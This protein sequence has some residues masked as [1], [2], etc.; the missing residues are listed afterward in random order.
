MTQTHET[1]EEHSDIVGGSTAGRRLNCPRSYALEQKVPKDPGSS[2]AREGTALHEMI[3]LILDKDKLP[4]ELLPFTFKRE[5]HD[6]EG[7]WEFTVDADLWADVGQPALDAFDQFV[8]EIEADQGAS[9]EY[10]IEKRCA[11]PGIPGAFGTSDV[12]WK[13]GK[14]SGVWDWKFGRNKVEAD[15]N[16]QL[17]FYGRAAAADHPEMF[18]AASWGEIDP[19]R[20]VI[21]S[22]MQPKC[23]DEPSEYIVTVEELEAFRVELMKAVEVAKSAGETA[24][25]AKGKWCDYATCKAIC[26]LWAGRTVTMG[27]K[28]AKLADMRRDEDPGDHP[29]DVGG[30]DDAFIDL[31]PELLDLAD[32]AEE[33]LK[34]IRAAALSVL[35]EGGE[36]DGWRLGVSSTNRR[37]WAVEEDEVKSFF[38][39]R[40]YKLDEYMPRQ[41]VTMPAAEKMLK[42]D[43]RTIPDELIEKKVS[44]KN[45]LVR[46]DSSL[47]APELSSAGAKALG[48]KLAALAGSDPEA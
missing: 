34:T 38:K 29:E 5:G 36:I 44:T 40:R 14:L 20:E 7:D 21:L 43:G 25:V 26:P 8:E 32:S 41:L 15:E 2:Y 35:D 1:P 22:I 12:I 31:L 6:V 23:G 3:A 27:Q 13:C 9:F 10:I 42:R 37:V 45:A 18:G 4:E 39:N 28:M 33:W 17:K 24:P 30:V 19:K 47:P 16:P 48:D 46:E 11:M